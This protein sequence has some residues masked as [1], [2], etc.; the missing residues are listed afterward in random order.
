M[1]I[2][3]STP[4]FP[5]PRIRK[6]AGGIYVCTGGGEDGFGNTPESAYRCWQTALRIKLQRGYEWP[7]P[8]DPGCGSPYWLYS[9]QCVKDAEATERMKESK[10]KR[11]P[12]RHIV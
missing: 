2:S 7:T 10:H 4:C 9:P 8:F 5:K 3:H 12:L 1:I 6:A 11:I